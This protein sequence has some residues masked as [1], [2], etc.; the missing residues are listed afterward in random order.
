[1]KQY[2]AFP[3]ILVVVSW[4]ATSMRIQVARMSRVLSFSASASAS[5]KW[6]IRSSLGWLRRASINGSSS[7][8]SF[9]SDGNVP[10]G[11]F[12]ISWMSD[13]KDID[14]SDRTT[15]RVVLGCHTPMHS[16]FSYTTGQL[17]L[18]RV[19]HPRRTE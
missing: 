15:L 12:S 19:D 11:S 2:I 5:S 7:S 3:I 9:V 8:A 10:L 1:V 4:P 6:L 13:T 18:D 14:S 16:I 17:A